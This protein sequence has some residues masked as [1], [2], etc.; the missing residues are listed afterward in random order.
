LSSIGRRADEK[1]GMGMIV[2]AML[3]K[4]IKELAGEYSYSAGN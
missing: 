1:T 4:S 2:G 3:G